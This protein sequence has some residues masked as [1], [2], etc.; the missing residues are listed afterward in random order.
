MITFEKLKKYLNEKQIG[1]IIFRSKIIELGHSTT[2]DQYRRRLTILGFLSEPIKP[3]IYK[4]L[5]KI[6]EEYNTSD[7]QYAYKNKRVILKK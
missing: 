5:K 7:L 4:L 1:D 2:I 3:G 6:S